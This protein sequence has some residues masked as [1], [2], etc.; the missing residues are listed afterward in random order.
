MLKRL[1]LLS[2]LCVLLATSTCSAYTITEQELSKLESNL[3]KLSQSNE[4]LLI[5][6]GKSK[7]TLVEVQTRLEEL[8]KQLLLSQNEL[9]LVKNNL[10]QTT[11][12]LET[13]NQSLKESEKEIKLMTWQRNLAL[14]AAVLIALLK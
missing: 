14:G 2:L 10:N 8:K 4:I 6:L 12:S 9:S 5:D 7:M 13:A 1:L 3:Q 11:N